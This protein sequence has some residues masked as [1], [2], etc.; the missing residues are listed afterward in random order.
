MSKVGNVS[1]AEAL[2]YV[3]N[4]DIGANHEMG[5]NAEI[6]SPQTLPDFKLPGDMAVLVGSQI[7]GFAAS[8]NAEIRP[9]IANAF[10]LAQLAANK[11]ASKS[12][13][14]SKDWY[15]AYIDVLT[16][17]GWVVEG[18]ANSMQEV[19][20]R[21]SDMHR[22]IIP[23]IEAALGPAVAAASTITKVLKGL[24]NISKDAPWITLFDQQSQ[25][26]HANQFQISNTTGTTA[27]PSIK[28]V[29]FELDAS[30]SVTQVLFFKFSAN[31]A[32]LRKFESSMSVNSEVFEGVKTAIA[33]KLS[34]LTSQ[35]VSKIDL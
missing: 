12:K 23:V 9:H 1:L 21:N 13:G 35:Y 5:Q 25:R 26:A 27:N 28:L 24:S 32:K 4:A 33:Q 20:V 17:I 8:V 6:E 10:L 14:R 19:A 18:D 15:E 34:G 3:I 30:A 29:G 16:N 7:V 2:S 31:K 22:E 11:K